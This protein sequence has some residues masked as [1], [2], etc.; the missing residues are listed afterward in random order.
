MLASK[1]AGVSV[2][3]DVQ[4]QRVLDALVA[5]ILGIVAVGLIFF[6]VRGAFTGG[7]SNA[8]DYAGALLA[9]LFL[10]VLF[11]LPTLIFV[12]RSTPT[13]AIKRRL[14]AM[15]LKALSTEVEHLRQSE[16]VT[17]G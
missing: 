17:H 2:P 9:F 16:R 10:V 8:L 4:T 12:R 11:A 15:R 1:S 6:I 13:R 7:L 5:Q 14:V 3:I